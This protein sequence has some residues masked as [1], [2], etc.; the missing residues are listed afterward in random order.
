MSASSLNKAAGARTRASLVIAGV[1]MALIIVALGGP[2]DNIAMPALAGLLILVGVRTI[3]PADLASVWKTGL[4]QRVVL[5]TTFLLTIVIPLQ[6]AVLAGVGLSVALYVVGQ[7]NK[8]TIKRRSFTDD[9]HVIEVDPPERLPARPGCHSA[10][11]R[12]L[13]LRGRPDLCRRPAGADT[14]VAKQRRD[15]APART[16]RHRLDVHRRASSDTPKA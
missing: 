11:L 14:R 5:V 16:Q 3:K 15:S 8:V 13:V 10:A 4:P 2:I 7:S 12:Q 6:Y 1:V 9:G